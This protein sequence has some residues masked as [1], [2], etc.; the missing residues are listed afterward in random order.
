MGCRIRCF[1]SSLPVNG[2]S[3]IRFCD[4][5]WRS[6]NVT[7]AVVLQHPKAFVFVLWE[8]WVWPLTFSVSVYLFAVQVC[9]APDESFQGK[10]VVHAV[11]SKCSKH[12]QHQ[13]NQY[14]SFA[15]IENLCSAFSIEVICSLTQLLFF[16]PFPLDLIWHF[17]AIDNLSIWVRETGW[18]YTPPIAQHSTAT[19]L[20]IKWKWT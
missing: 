16:L 6:F 8:H 20:L 10:Q 17:W 18:T 14:L 4:L 3:F 2:G 5:K 19:Y 1:V 11:F 9:C 15:P 12:I 13:I 7:S